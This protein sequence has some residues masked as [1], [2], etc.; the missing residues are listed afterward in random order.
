MKIFRLVIFLGIA[1]FKKKNIV[2]KSLSMSDP[3]SDGTI[4]TPE[5]CTDIIQESKIGMIY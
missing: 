4:L 5:Y 3:G 1:I 2:T